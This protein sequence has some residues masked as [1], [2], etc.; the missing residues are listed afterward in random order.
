MRTTAPFS[1]NRA[2]FL[3]RFVEKSE[4]TGPGGV[5]FPLPGTGKRK[6]RGPPGL[7]RFAC[8]KPRRV[9]ARGRKSIV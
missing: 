9:C 7:R 2:V 1:E 5:R 8:Q 4:E 3:R 6:R